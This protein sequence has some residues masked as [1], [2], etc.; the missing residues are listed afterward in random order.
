M[1]DRPFSKSSKNNVPA[2]A[3]NERLPIATNM[4]AINNLLLVG[5]ISSIPFGVDSGFSWYTSLT[6]EPRAKFQALQ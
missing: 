3:P 2:Q 5:I 6:E 4:V 1:P